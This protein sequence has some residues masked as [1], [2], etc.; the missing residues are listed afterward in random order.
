MRYSRGHKQR[1]HE[2]ILEAAGR[3]F[4]QRGYTSAGIDTVMEEAGLTPGGF[5]AHF[6]SKEALLIE[7]LAHATRCTREKLVAGLET[8]E[9]FDW[10]RAVVDRYLSQHHCR[11]APEGCPMPALISEIARA[12]SG[13]KKAFEGLIREIV[14]EFE[15]KMSSQARKISKDRALAVVALCIGGIALAR[16]VHN[17][18]LSD[19]IL[20]AC[21]KVALPK[22][23]VGTR[24][25]KN[26]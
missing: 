11:I 2:R 7:T 19:R 4:R 15:R 21:R 1:T 14:A 23:S 5:Y 8:T 12:G 20:K 3:I 16:A 22:R 18:M 10:L 13:P 6:A 24:Q 26:Q 25:R 17:P 9:G